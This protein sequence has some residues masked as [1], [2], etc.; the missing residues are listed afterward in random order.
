MIAWCSESFVVGR[1]GY[2][3]QVDK[4]GRVDSEKD[5]G[6]S[7]R[8][9]ASIEEP[10]GAVCV[11]DHAPEALQRRLDRS[12][13]DPGHLDGRSVDSLRSVQDS[14]RIHV[15]AKRINL[16]GRE[17]SSG[18]WRDAAASAIT[19]GSAASSRATTASR[20]TV[21]AASNQRNHTERADT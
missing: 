16:L 18:A 20:T 1:Y 17:E 9:C 2:V 14:P 10:H 5:R 19:S 21:L 7:K 3:T 6:G 13:N 12:R 4:H 8:G 15:R 11:P